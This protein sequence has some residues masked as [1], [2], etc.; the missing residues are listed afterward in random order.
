MAQVRSQPSY[1]QVA[2]ATAK[3]TPRSLTTL[4]PSLVRARISS[5]SNSASPL[6]T[7][8][9]RRPRGL[10]VSAQLSLRL[11]K[12]APLG[13]RRNDVEQVAGRA[14]RLGD[15]QHVAGLDPTKQWI[16]PSR[17]RRSG[18]SAARYTAPCA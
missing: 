12:P 18:R 15:D 11:L 2:Y 9:M 5:R 1:L 3:L 10:V 17:T 6:S 16:N 7:M 14:G 4:R 8:S 13:E